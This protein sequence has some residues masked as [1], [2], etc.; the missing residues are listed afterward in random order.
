MA[1]LEKKKIILASHGKLAEGFLDTL[2]LLGADTAS[3]EYLDFYDEDGATEADAIRLLQETD[4]DTL[5]VI[6]TDIMFGS[7]NQMFLRLA[8]NIEKKNIRIITGFNLPVALAVIM[9][10]DPLTDDKLCQ[11]VS[12]GREQLLLMPMN[13]LSKQ[14]SDDDIFED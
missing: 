13:I 6:F 5:L 4:E 8:A 12:D 3:V 1:G 10:E 7:V 11:L 14:N 2:T 9:A